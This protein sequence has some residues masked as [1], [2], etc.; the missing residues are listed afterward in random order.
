[1]RKV[2][3]RAATCGRRDGGCDG[4][5]W[6][7]RC[8]SWWACDVMELVQSCEA[9]HTAPQGQSVHCSPCPNQGE[10]TML[11]SAATCATRSIT[12]HRNTS[13]PGVGLDRLC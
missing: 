4:S 5:G 10:G 13:G 6:A 12:R 8:K 1:M 9:G 2:G 7:C 3:C 11:D